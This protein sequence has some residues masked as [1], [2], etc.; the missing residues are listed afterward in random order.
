MASRIE[1]YAL[2][3]D[4]GSAALAAKDGSIDRLC[5]LSR[6]SF[7]ARPSAEHLR[8]TVIRL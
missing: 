8:V 3:G 7:E 6:A 5:W 4:R 1:D 2:I